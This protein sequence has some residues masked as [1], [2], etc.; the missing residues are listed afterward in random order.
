MNRLLTSVAITIA[1][2]IALWL[3]NSLAGDI[4]TVQ[5]TQCWE[6]GCCGFT[7][8]YNQWSCVSAENVGI[9]RDT[10]EN[11][12]WVCNSSGMTHENPDNC[13]YDLCNGQPCEWRCP[14]SEWGNHCV[15]TSGNV[16]CQHPNESTCTANVYAIQCQSMAGVNDCNST[17]SPLDVR[18]CWVSGG[19][20]PIPGRSV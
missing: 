6:P 13:Q 1:I 12:T 17:V 9:C 11:P 20:P 3:G 2:T 19:L 8:V 18:Q 7:L 5:A 15:I 14:L 16:A 10:G 4:E